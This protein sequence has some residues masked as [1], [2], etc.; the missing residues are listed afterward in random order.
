[1]LKKSILI[2]FLIAFVAGTEISTAQAP[3]P[4]PGSGH[5]VS[6]NSAPS[7]SPGGGA[8]IGSGLAIL[9]SLG[10]VYGAYKMYRLKQ[11]KALEE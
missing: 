1:M 6:T 4:P 5:G 9:V 3:P 8:P 10:L 7:N 2:L 11:L